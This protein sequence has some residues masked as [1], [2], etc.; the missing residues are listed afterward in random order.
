M[1]LAVVFLT[2]ALAPFCSSANLFE[3]L[4]SQD[5]SDVHVEWKQIEFETRGYELKIDGKFAILTNSC[6]EDD[7]RLCLCI[8]NV[9]ADKNR[10]HHLCPP[11]TLHICLTKR[12]KN[13]AYVVN[14]ADEGFAVVNFNSLNGNLKR[15]NEI[16]IE[17]VDGY[18][19]SSEENVFG[20]RSFWFEYRSTDEEGATK[21]KSARKRV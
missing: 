4:Y 16:K 18:P 9:L 19:T 17:F 15:K 10:L 13:E 11:G 1:H 5:I 14:P 8:Q 21:W 2:L 7:S 6:L 3:P 12:P 20:E